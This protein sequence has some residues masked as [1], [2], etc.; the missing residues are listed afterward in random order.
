[1][2]GD[3]EDRMSKKCATIKDSILLTRIPGGKEREN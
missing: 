3:G 2:A 1:M